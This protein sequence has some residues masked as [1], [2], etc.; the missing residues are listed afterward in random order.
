MHIRI[1]IINIHVYIYIYI[2]IYT[3]IHTYI[4]TYIFVFAVMMIMSIVKKAFFA[5]D[6]TCCPDINIED[7]ALSNKI[8]E[9]AEIQRNT[10]YTQTFLV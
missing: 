4:H 7:V 6:S 2:H 1:F 3:Y 10:A 9:I 5:T 8:G